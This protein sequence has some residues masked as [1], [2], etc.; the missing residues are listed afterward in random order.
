[1]A[2]SVKCHKCQLVPKLV[3]APAWC[4]SAI[5]FRY[6]T[7]TRAGV[8]EERKC[9]NEFGTPAAASPTSRTL[10]SSYEPTVCTAVGATNLRL[11][12]KMK[13]RTSLRVMIKENEN[14]KD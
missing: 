8:L 6:G 4:H 2:T 12:K 7:G 13:K 10:G 14:P 11:L 5:F 1:M 9:Q 3:M